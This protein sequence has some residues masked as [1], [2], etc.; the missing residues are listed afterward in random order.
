MPE[1]LKGS[2]TGRKIKNSI[3]LG[4]KKYNLVAIEYYSYVLTAWNWNQW[5]FLPS[6]IRIAEAGFEYL[7]R[8]LEEKQYIIHYCLFAF[9]KFPASK[10]GNT[11]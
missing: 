6:I 4:E 7:S 1:N 5:Q 8:F 9:R 11:L 2:K 3:P 10:T